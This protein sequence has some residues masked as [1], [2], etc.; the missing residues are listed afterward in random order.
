M[1]RWGFAVLLLANIGLLMWASWYRQPAGE[2]PQ[3]RQ[4]F[5]PELMVPLNTPGVAL[6]ARKSEPSEAPLAATKPRQRCIA[7]GPFAPDPAGKAGAWLAGEKFE[8][9]RRGEER[10]IEN[11]YWIYLAPFATRKE[12]ERRLQELERLGLR[13][14]LIMPATQGQIAISLGLF[15]QAEN[16]QNRL[17]ELA[18]KGIEASQEIRYRTEPVTWLDLR[19]PEPADAAVEQL[20]THD[21]GAA[22][23]EVRENACPPEP[24]G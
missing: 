3:P 21:W 20:R 15:T 5:H 19:L 17:K 18:Q 6:R 2:A 14:L 22:G 11:S 16:A 4:V 7:I 13:D 1:M 12:A 23:I 9:A 10:K 8:A 24:A